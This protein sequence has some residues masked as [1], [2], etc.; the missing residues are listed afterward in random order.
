MQRKTSKVIN[1]SA[2]LAAILD[3]QHTSRSYD[4][5]STITRKHDPE[6][7]EV[8]V[9]VLSLCALE[10]EICLG[11]FTPPPPRCRQTSQK[12]VTGRVVKGSYFWVKG[13]GGRGRKGEVGREG[14]ERGKGN[15]GDKSPAHM[16]EIY[17][18]HFPWQHCDHVH[19]PSS[20]KFNK[21]ADRLLT[22]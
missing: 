16:R 10:L 21:S 19:W 12:T 7:I 5:D 18:L 15:E 8:A 2:N 20:S 3:F 4:I 9:G 14:K 22:I 13:R 6:N 1:T 11:V 17:P